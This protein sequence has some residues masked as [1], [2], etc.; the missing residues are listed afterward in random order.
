[1]INIIPISYNLGSSPFENLYGF[2]LDYST[3]CVFGSTCFVL[4]PYIECNK[5]SLQST[6]WVLLCFGTDQKEYHYFDLVNQK[7]NVSRY[8]MFLEH[9]HIFFI[10]TNSHNKN[11]IHFDPSYGDTKVVPLTISHPC[12]PI[13]DYESCRVNTNSSTNASTF[14]P[15]APIDSFFYTTL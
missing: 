1:M 15:D 3:F 6:I 8:V 14:L 4:Q 9:L 10:L 7:L 12:T 5:L 11:L 13:L 2:A